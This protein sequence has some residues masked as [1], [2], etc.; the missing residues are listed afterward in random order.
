MNRD[1]LDDVYKFID[2]NKNGVI[3][4]KEFKYYFYDRDFLEKEAQEHTTELDDELKLLFRRIDHQ[5][6]GYVSADEVVRCLNILGY[7]ATPEMIGVEFK[8]YDFD[9]D[10]RMNFKEFRRFMINKMRGTVFRMDHM[11]DEI[12]RKFRKV[13][14]TDG[15]D[16]DMI[17]FGTAMKS[18]SPDLTVDEVQSLFYEIDEEHSGFVQLEE[19]AN[20]LKT[21]P[22][23]QENPLTSNAILK[24]KKSNVLSLRD[25]ASVYEVVPQNFCT[26]STRVNFMQLKNLPSDS[27]YPK[28]LP[29]TLGFSDIYGQF[30]DTKS[31][32]TFPIKPLE[33]RF[34]RLITLDIATGVPIPEESDK[35]IRKNFVT[36]REIR[37]V[38]FDRNTHKYVGGTICMPAMWREDYEDRWTLEKPERDCSFYVRTPDENSSLCIIFEFVLYIVVKGIE[39]QMSCCW[40]S[41]DLSNLSKNGTVELPLFGGVP[42]ISTQIHNSDVRTHRGTLFGK[43]G[44][45]FGGNI[46][47]EL[48]IKVQMGDS[49][50]PQMRT[51]LDLLPRTL[52]VP[53]EA[54]YLWRAYRCY[55]GNKAYQNHGALNTQLG[56]DII[57]RT[58]LRCVNVQS[59]HRRLCAVWNLTGE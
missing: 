20:Y 55:V 46:K 30:A 44:K 56:S 28:L 12:K 51:A 8:D 32:V 17:Q 11:L 47:S 1:E 48:K 39:L 43:I 41:I 23:N 54:V 31:K 45:F 2:F 42:S 33:S 40:S 25:L 52:L 6:S 5:K 3:S 59:F 21:T 13:H 10:Q 4:L 9:R 38:L 29:N 14:P 15:Q 37:A 58:F 57:L 7:P 27:L 26:A 18:I 49:V 22:D 50:R 24:M 19:I 16:Y 36:A 35:F 53:V 34:L